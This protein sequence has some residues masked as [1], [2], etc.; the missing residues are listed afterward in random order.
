MNRFAVC[1]RGLNLKSVYLRAF[2]ENKLSRS[3]FQTK[4]SL[5]AGQNL[6]F[7]SCLDL[8]KFHRFLSIKLK[9]VNR[10]LLLTFLTK[11]IFA[12]CV[13]LRFFD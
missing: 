10:I 12:F 2:I 7:G 11:Q 5:N 3:K 13:L 9:K 4:I 1:H 6:Y 8:T